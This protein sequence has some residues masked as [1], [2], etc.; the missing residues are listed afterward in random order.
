YSQVI[1]T[2][3]PTYAK[4]IQTPEYGAGFEGILAAR[5]ADLFGIL[6]G[7]DTD[8][9]DPSRD[10]FLPEP[11]DENSLEIKDA[12]RLELIDTIGAPSGADTLPR[13]IIGLVSRLVDQKGF[14][15]ISQIAPRLPALGASFAVLGTGDPR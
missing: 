14:D 6:N 8:R 2:V 15:L 1:T 7:I 12:S 4:E 11:Y 13:P 3:S 5:S 10:P 9:W